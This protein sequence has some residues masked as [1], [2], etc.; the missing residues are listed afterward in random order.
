MIDRGIMYRRG[1]SAPDTERKGWTIRR[2][3][4]PD[5]PPPQRP[6]AQTPTT[7]SATDDGTSGSHSTSPPAP[8]PVVT[9][10]AT[11]GN[12]DLVVTQ[13]TIEAGDAG[14]GARG[15]DG[16][17]EGDH[18]EDRSR[19]TGA[20]KGNAALQPAATPD[21]TRSAWGQLQQT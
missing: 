7:K 9:E 5:P 17:G 18:G 14:R 11:E 10:S 16:G 20:G 12:G 8:A 13:A 21:A 4:T 6:A 3:K 2:R 1:E 15:R 19:P